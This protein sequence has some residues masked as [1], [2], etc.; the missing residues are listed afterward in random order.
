LDI[1]KNQPTEIQIRANPMAK[2]R[3]LCA[4]IDYHLLTGKNI[5]STRDGN[6]IDDESGYDEQDL[7]ELISRARESATNGKALY[8]LLHDI[9]R[10]K[11][12]SK[13]NMGDFEKLNTHLAARRTALSIAVRPEFYEISI[14]MLKMFR[15]AYIK[16]HGKIPRQEP[17]ERKQ[18]I[19]PLLNWQ[20]EV[21]KAPNGILS[22]Y[23][24]NRL[25]LACISA[26]ERGRK[27]DD[28]VWGPIFKI[29]ESQ[30]KLRNPKSAPIKEDAFETVT[31]IK[32]TSA[33][34]L[35]P[36]IR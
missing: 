11:D 3:W 27:P 6:E 23:E 25:R 4:V 36:H 5:F 26:E 28:P 15:S 33:T 13:M 31:S 8:T 2:I 12:P 20:A 19:K 9:E 21:A 14:T 24:F 29:F 7:Q 34:I 30:E 18:T 35:N 16:T 17:S 22:K 32:I 1:A 10:F